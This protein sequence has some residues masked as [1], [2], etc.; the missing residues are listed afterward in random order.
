[1]PTSL[2]TPQ[3]KSEGHIEALEPLATRLQRAKNASIEQAVSG[4]IFGGRS[5]GAGRFARGVPSVFSPCDGGVDADTKRGVIDAM[6]L[7]GA[8]GSL[9]T[10]D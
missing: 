4:K 5:R 7:K 2:R 8:A 6:H 3:D 1:M 9:V 10:I